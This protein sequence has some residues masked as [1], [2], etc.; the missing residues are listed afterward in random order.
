M[1]K[2]AK[3]K[4]KRKAE[5]KFQ[6]HIYVMC[7]WLVND[8]SFAL[9]VMMMSSVSSLLQSVSQVLVTLFW[10][11]LRMSSKKPAIKYLMHVAFSEQL[12]NGVT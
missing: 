4:I 7:G 5:F 6:T 3:I 9:N 8:V 1:N 2:E 12:K 10:L 11:L